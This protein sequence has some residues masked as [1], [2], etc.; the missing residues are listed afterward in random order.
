MRRSN[1]LGQPGLHYIQKLYLKRMMSEGENEREQGGNRGREERS[2][3]EG[4]IQGRREGGRSKGREREEGRE[5]E[6]D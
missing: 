6:R 2:R 5:R 1:I 3:R 4:V